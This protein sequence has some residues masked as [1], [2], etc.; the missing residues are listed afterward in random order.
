MGILAKRL[1]YA[2][3]IILAQIISPPHRNNDR[4]IVSE[5]P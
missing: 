1:W 4:L 5:V 2:S 3:H